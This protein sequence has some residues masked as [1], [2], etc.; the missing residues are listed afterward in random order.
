MTLRSCNLLRGLAIAGLLAVLGVPCAQA[1]VPTQ[2]L[3]AA[4]VFPDPALQPGYE[5]SPDTA[6]LN[7]S[8]LEQ[9]ERNPGAPMAA[10]PFTVQPGAT[11]TYPPRVQAPYPQLTPQ[12]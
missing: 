9:I 12:R 10:T 7:R 3:P 2:M 5:R 8:M 4:P 6:A 11:V 1:Q